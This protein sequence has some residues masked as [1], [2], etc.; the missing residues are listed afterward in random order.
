[1][2]EIHLGWVLMRSFFQTM[3]SW[4]LFCVVV[5]FQGGHIANIIGRSVPKKVLH[6]FL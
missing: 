5:F 6:T 2:D 3:D 4:H 1:M